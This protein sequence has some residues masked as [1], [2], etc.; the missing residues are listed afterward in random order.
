[1]PLVGL[2]GLRGFSQ[3]GTFQNV[4]FAPVS[5]FPNSMERERD[6]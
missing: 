2:D 6:A 5:A 3:R 1:M 4:I